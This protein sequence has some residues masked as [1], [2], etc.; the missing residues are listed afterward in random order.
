[1]RAGMNALSES[2]LNGYH[3]KNSP[4][5]EVK[6]VI[7]RK[8]QPEDA[9][10][11]S[12]LWLEASLRAH[13]FIAESYWREREAEI[14]DCY[15]PNSETY[16]LDHQGQPVAFVSMLEHDYL[17]ALFVASDYQGQG[18]G[19]RLLN[20]VKQNRETIELNVYKENGN[21]VRFYRRNGFVPVEERPDP[22]TGHVEYRMKWES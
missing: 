21:A 10:S 3:E 22:A 14:R 20:E 17:A 5:D 2:Y 1:M 18:C 9:V 19:T 6:T 11:L 4:R 12:Q 7:L 8:F 15:L 13:S 16:V